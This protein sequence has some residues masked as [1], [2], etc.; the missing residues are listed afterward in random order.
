MGI[1]TTLFVKKNIGKCSVT[2]C[3][4]GGLTNITKGNNN[5]K[6]LSLKMIRRTFWELAA[7]LK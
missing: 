1:Q 7:T 2:S 3:L 4:Q 6:G 5:V